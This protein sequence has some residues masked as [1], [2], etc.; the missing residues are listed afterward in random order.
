[1]KNL[2]LSFVII[3]SLVFGFSFTYQR[4]K[5]DKLNGTFQVF[6]NSFNMIESTPVASEYSF[7]DRKNDSLIECF[8][9]YTF[10]FD[11]NFVQHHFLLADVNGETD[12]YDTIKAEIIKYELDDGGGV[13]KYPGFWNYKIISKPNDLLT[14]IY[15][16]YLTA[17][18]C[19]GI[20]NQT[21]TTNWIVPITYTR[22]IR[23][24]FQPN[25][26]D[27]GATL[28]QDRLKMST[29]FGGTSS[30]VIDT[31]PSIATYSQ[32]LILA[33]NVTG[34]KIEITTDTSNINVTQFK[35]IF[36]VANSGVNPF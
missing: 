24:K 28:E 6:V 8:Q 21:W 10:D 23:V 25:H 26:P 9:M 36:G 7:Q 18:S 13:I 33:S 3:S 20:P 1:M 19:I 22:K 34:V 16:D 17:F 31:G 11:S 5:E 27:A 32:D 29:L 15:M 2:I 12:S 30:V 14:N 35:W 4:Q